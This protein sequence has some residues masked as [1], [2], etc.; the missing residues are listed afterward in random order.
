MR[1]ATS[2]RQCARAVRRDVGTAGLLV[3]AAVLL[4]ASALVTG[5]YF[6][7]QASDA[8][9]IQS[10]VASRAGAAV[11]ALNVR[12]RARTRRPV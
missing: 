5:I 1:C 12:P 4:V 10:E 11:Q 2:R 6:L 7:E 3:V 9:L 8:E